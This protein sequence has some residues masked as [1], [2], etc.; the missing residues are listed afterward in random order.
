MNKAQVL[1]SFWA[2][3]GAAYDQNTVPEDAPFPRITYE[4]ATDGFGQEL[5]LSASLWDRNT[6][7]A[8]VEALKESISDII[9]Y[10]GVNVSYDSGMLWIKRGTP[11]AQRMGDSDD[12]IR[13][14]VLNIEVEYLGG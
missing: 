9:G 5:I 10:G 4:V 6:S 7:W 3:F 1:H 12:S 14:I 13:R 8:R 11:F 2:G